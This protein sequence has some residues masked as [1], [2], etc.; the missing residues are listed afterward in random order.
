VRGIVFAFLL[1]GCQGE[2]VTPTQSD[3]S[4]ADAA[5]GNLLTNG[6]F[7]LGCAGW[8]GFESRTEDSNQGRNG[9]KAC[10]VCGD[11][12]VD[13]FGIEARVPIDKLT[14][15]KTYVGEVWVRAAPSDASAA[16]DPRAVFYLN[17]KEMA[18]Y[19]ESKESAPV[20][21]DS[22]WKRLSVVITVRPGT[23]DL[24]L[25]VLLH[26]RATCILV[27]DAVVRPI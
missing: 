3:A 26:E 10:M 17:D 16:P 18:T 23:T 7:E 5:S 19:I 14:V 9:G 22:T 6:D 25:D 1:M 11:P 2:S 15:G 24:E 27:D 13:G 8:F 12:T 4:V 21:A 20:T